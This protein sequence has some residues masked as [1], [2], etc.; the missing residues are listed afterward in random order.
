MMIGVMQVENLGSLSSAEVS[1][2]D[3]KRTDSGAWWFFAR[4]PRASGFEP[5]WP[6]PAHTYRTPVISSC[7]MGWAEA[8]LGLKASSYEMTLPCGRSGAQ[9]Q[10]RHHHAAW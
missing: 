7:G 3:A 6:R 4:E 9:Q 5:T 10:R 8:L 1:Y 2:A